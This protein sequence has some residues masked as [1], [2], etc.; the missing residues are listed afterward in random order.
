MEDG[1]LG[2]E[3]LAEQA[4]KAGREQNQ[5]ERKHIY[6]L[7]QMFLTLKNFFAQTEG[8]VPKLPVGHAITK[9]KLQDEEIGDLKESILVITASEKRYKEA[10]YECDKKRAAYIDSET[11]NKELSERLARL[12][13][14]L[15]HRETQLG[16]SF[17]ECD[18][19]RDALRLVSNAYGCFAGCTGNLPGAPQDGS[20][21]TEVCRAAR[22]LAFP[23]VSA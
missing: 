4:A 15:S 5:E 1:D 20:G 18:I 12:E 7:T 21:H 6:E 2:A 14:V 8:K 9:I 10:F 22:A 16:I 3:R 13:K 17:S 23:E 19:L 11:Q